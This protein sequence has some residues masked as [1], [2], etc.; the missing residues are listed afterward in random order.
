MNFENPKKQRDIAKQEVL[1][2]KLIELEKE[3]GDKLKQLQIHEATL[4][5]EK[6]SLSQLEGICSHQ[7]K[8]TAELR[9]HL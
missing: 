9:S 4:K 6:S 3:Y 1:T 5:E 7:N 8:E 2:I